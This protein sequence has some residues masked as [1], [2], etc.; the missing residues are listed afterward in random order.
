MLDLAPD[1]ISASDKDW[2]VMFLNKAGRRMIGL[3]ED[4]DV[5]KLS[6]YKVHPEWV[7]KIIGG[8]GLTTA[9]REGIWKGET[10][11]LGKDGQE[12]PVSQV[13][14]CHKSPDGEIQYHS[15]ICRD[16]TQEKKVREEL[17][18]HRDN[19]EGLV[20][21]RT[22]ELTK[23]AEIINRQAQEI[24]EVSTPVLQVFEGVVVAPLI[25]TLDS[26]RT[27]RF[28]ERLL[29]RIVE[30]NSPVALVDITGVPTID[31]QTAQHL[32]D[33]ISAVKL[34]GARVILTG[35]RPAIA[36]TLVHLGIDLSGI[37]TRSSL[38]SGLLVA[39]DSLGLRM[40]G[41]NKSD[42]ERD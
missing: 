35:V 27:Q 19:L 31:T 20:Q 39:M 15:T 28:M 26:Q 34:L 5:K 16:I 32:I 14:L 3:D 1:Y 37:T 23:Q 13:I 41:G 11:I 6:V 12:I 2:N 8:E 22:A 25:G 21:E 30:T 38:A 7:V 33:T 42:E 40:V 9:D 29:E 24:L 4:T 17:R 10:A 36:Q 18:K